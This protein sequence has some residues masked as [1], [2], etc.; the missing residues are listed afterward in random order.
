MRILVTCPPMI[1]AAD[2]F[3]P[4]FEE[5][6][7]R[8][9]VPE[10]VQV[11][12]EDDLIRVL[13]DCDGW[14][15]GD[16]PATARVFEAGRRG[17]L[18]AA[19]KW[20]IGVDNVDFDACNRLGIPITN[21]PKMFGSEVADVAV[22]YVI[23]LARHLFEI[24]D[25]VKNG[26]WHKP[27]GISLQNKQAGVI[28]FGDIGKSVCKRLLASD[29]KIT[30]WDPGIS[31]HIL[32][33]KVTLEKWPHGLGD[34]DFLIFTCALTQQNIHMLNARTLE[35]CKRGVRIVNVA[36]GP[37]INECDLIQ[38]LENGQVG[39][40]ALDVFEVEP[41]SKVNKLLAM[42]NVIVGSHNGSNSKDAV[43]RANSAVIDILHGF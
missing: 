31:S 20:G 28:G 26:T 19:V 30:I 29:L 22:G 36:R 8:A 16:D 25:K 1:A 5:K 41:V 43:E 34:C 9:L 13:P 10:F 12:S 24:N 35:L 27:Q 23:G 6:K 17:K 7:W 11:M 15:I 3:L 33:D 18:K 42:P 4:L 21:T 32:Q 38:A 37:L 2:H 40:A 39:S 14:I